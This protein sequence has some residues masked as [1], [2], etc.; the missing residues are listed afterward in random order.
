LWE[1]FAAIEATDFS[2]WY[3]AANC[4]R[5]DNAVLRDV[6]SPSGWRFRASYHH[7]AIMY[8]RAFQILPAVHREFRATWFSGID[9][10]LFTSPTQL[11]FGV[12][13]PPDTGMFMAYP[14]WDDAGDSLSFVPFPLRDITMGQP[15]TYPASHRDAV[16]H[17][18]ELMRRVATTWRAV[19]PASSDAMLAVA[20]SVD[21]LGDV[22][23]I[24][25]LRVARTLAATADERLRIAIAQ[26]WLQVK[27]GMPD[28]VRAL[29]VARAMADSLLQ[30]NPNPAPAMVEALASIALLTGRVSL[31][32]ALAN[33]GYELVDQVTPPS[34]KKLATRQYC[35]ARDSGPR[36]NRTDGDQYTAK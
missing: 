2:A 11:R 21:K 1:R 5:A 22:S 23:A 9:D 12:A 6:R 4:E 18:R 20:V 7:A 28:D 27:Y 25:S 26:V 10:V 33:S 31:G 8:S 29:R 15:W 34:V 32:T 3:G 16:R 17:Q 24:D 35:T 36:R 13:S 14:S 19:F 30:F